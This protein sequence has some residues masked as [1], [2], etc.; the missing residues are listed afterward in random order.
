MPGIRP[1]DFQ[2]AGARGAARAL[3]GGFCLALAV[4]VAQA[5]GVLPAHT[6]R[7]RRGGHHPGLGDNS[8]GPSDWQGRVI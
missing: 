7:G 2:R 4:T 3:A 6:N 5:A 8:F 1:R